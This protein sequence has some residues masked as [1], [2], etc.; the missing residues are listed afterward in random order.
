MYE[1]KTIKMNTAA[2][3]ENDRAL[4]KAAQSIIEKLYAYEKHHIGCAIRTKAGKVYTGVHV[5]G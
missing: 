1:R 2:L 5:A 3:T 4:V